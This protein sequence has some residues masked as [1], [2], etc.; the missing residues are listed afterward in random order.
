MKGFREIV[1]GRYDE[2][3]EQA[4]YLKRTLDEVPEAGYRLQPAALAA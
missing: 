2:V 4:F 3:P 1:D